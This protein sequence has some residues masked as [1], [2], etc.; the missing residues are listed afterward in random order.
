MLP[1]KTIGKGGISPSAC[2]LHD[3]TDEEVKRAF[4]AAV[5]VVNGLWVLLNCLLNGSGDLFD[6]DSLKRLCVD[7][8]ARGRSGVED[9][10]Y[11]LDGCVF[12]NGSLVHVGDDVD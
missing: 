8:L 11:D 9:S 4:L 6:W 1:N 10:S 2:L 7:D 5:I 12:G 3:L